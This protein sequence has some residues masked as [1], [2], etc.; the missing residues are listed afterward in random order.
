MGV[1][2]CISNISTKRFF[3]KQHFYR[4]YARSIILRGQKILKKGQ[5][6]GRLRQLDIEQE[7]GHK[8]R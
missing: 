6:Q 4:H 5:L 7:P 1:T 3:S 8:T 2:Y